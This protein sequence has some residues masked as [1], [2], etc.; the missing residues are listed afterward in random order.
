M[1]EPIKYVNSVDLSKALSHFNGK[2]DR[3]FYKDDD[4][5]Y[6]R[7]YRLCI[8]DKMP[9]DHYFYVSQFN[10]D[11]AFGIESKYL[12]NARFYFGESK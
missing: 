1:F 5:A 3:F 10:S 8:F 9:K 12:K 11:E 4:F 2:I 7:E 6:Q